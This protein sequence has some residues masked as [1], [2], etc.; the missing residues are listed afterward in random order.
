[1]VGPQAKRQAVQSI[2]DRLSESRACRLVGIGRSVIRYCSKR[3]EDPVL[4]E[5]IKFHAYERKRFGYRRILLLL[6]RKG[7]KV[8]HKR[9]FRL[10]REE[11]L[12]ML[13]RGGRKK[14]LGVRRPR[15]IPTKLNQQ[16]LLDFMADSLC[17][18]RKIRLL[19]IVDDYSRESLRV[20]VDTSLNGERVTRE[21][22]Q[23]VLER[24]VPEEIISDNGTE[25]TSRAILEWS[26][27]N[28]VAWRYIQPGKPIQNAY[29]ES[30]NGKIRDE[31]LNEHWFTSLE[32]ARQLVEA[33]R[34]DY[35]EKRPHT[36]L[37]GLTPTEFYT[38]IIGG[39]NVPA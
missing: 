1:M 35:N 29:I 14:A 4:K 32:E 15:I 10:Y 9:V 34:V 39:I 38:N 8:N 33:W 3:K 27:R 17:N 7:F 36:A 5:R 12:K 13:K 24:G 6:K 16:W 25:F 20:V 28:Q 21:L 22:N 11:G 2:R 19:T 30:F 26:E 18:G 37:K 23:L 31:C